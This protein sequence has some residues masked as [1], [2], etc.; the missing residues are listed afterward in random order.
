MQR[1]KEEAM[2]MEDT[3][4]GWLQKRIEKLKVVLR[5]VPLKRSEY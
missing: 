3:Q 1:E 4:K 2:Y 5:L